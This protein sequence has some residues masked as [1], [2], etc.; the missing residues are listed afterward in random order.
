MLLCPG[1]LVLDLCCPRTVSGAVPSLVNLA[2]LWLDVARCGSV[3]K[4]LRAFCVCRVCARMLVRMC[5][6]VCVCVVCLCVY[7]CVC[8]MMWWECV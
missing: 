1:G 8:L 7:A 4:C 2:V 6:F 3:W 5:V